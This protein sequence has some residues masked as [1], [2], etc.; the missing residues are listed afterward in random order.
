M[1]LKMYPLGTKIYLFDY[2]RWNNCAFIIGSHL[3][4]QD[5]APY[6]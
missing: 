1:I 2:D 6:K 4:N 3:L 5:D